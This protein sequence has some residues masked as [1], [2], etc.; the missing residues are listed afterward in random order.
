MAQS[1]T[2]EREIQYTITVVQN[3]YNLTKVVHIL[4]IKNIYF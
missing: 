1:P 3:H 2:D 4:K